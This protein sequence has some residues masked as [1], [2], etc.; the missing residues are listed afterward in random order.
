VYT[1][2][3]EDITTGNHFF[4]DS[5]KTTAGGDTTGKG[6]NPD[7]PFLTIEFAVGQCTANNGDRIHVMPGHA[8]T[9]A[10]DG[11][12]AQDVDGVR[13]TGIGEGDA[14]PLI[15]IGSAVEAAYIMSGAGCIMEHMR[16][17]IAIDAATDPIQMSGA[18]SILR[19]CEITEASAVEALDLISLAAGATRCKLHDLVIRGRNTTDGDALNAI[20]LDGCDDVEIYNIHAYGGD[21]SEA[22]IFNEGD[23]CLNVHIHHCLLETKAPED[24]SIVLDT[25]ATGNIHDLKLVLNDDAANIDQCIN[26]GNC[27]TF[28]PILVVNAVAEKGIEWPGTD[29]TDA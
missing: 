15:T 6:R 5:G 22:V 14:R 19:F 13:I 12:L 28:D 10:T 29:S 20:H 16:F 3:R 2:A 26:E 9:V 21:W 25:N 24:L 27:Y 1:I 17:S 18:G 11:G 7:F 4:V 23:E 8:E